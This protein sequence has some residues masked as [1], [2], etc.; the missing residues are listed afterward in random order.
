MFGNWMVNVCHT[1]EELRNCVKVKERESRTKLPT[2]LMTKNTMM[3]RTLMSLFMRQSLI[4]Y[5]EN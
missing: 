4:S 2:G 1:M 3:H 5:W